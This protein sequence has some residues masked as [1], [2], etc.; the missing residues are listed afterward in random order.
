[1]CILKVFYVWNEY[2]F[3]S[4]AKA[5]DIVK[6]LIHEQDIIYMSLFVDSMHIFQRRTAGHESFL[7]GNG[8]E[9]IVNY[10]NQSCDHRP[11]V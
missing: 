11:N 6:W 7:T 2:I 3:L 10:T 5:L 1:M 8:L 9:R 4:T